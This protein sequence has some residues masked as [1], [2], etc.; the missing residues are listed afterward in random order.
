MRL[1]LQDRE[2]SEGD[3]C[4]IIKF[5]RALNRVR[6][7]SF[8]ETNVSKTI[9]VLCLMISNSSQHSTTAQKEAEEL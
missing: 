8:V 1:S 5:S 3:F 9:S 7:F 2:V 4:L 6:L